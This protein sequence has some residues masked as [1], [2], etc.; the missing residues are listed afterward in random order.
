MASSMATLPSDVTGIIGRIEGEILGRNAGDTSALDEDMLARFLLP[1]P[2]RDSDFRV[3]GLMVAEVGEVTALVM[4]APRDLLAPESAEEPGVLSGPSLGVLRAVIRGVSQSSIA[5]VSMRPS[6]G[7]EESAGSGRLS[8]SITA[9]L[10][11]E[12][13]CCKPPACASRAFSRVEGVA[14]TA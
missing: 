14:G 10:G 13:G 9:P 5:E 8:S 11:E 1:R 6:T 2:P 12:R 3:T 7:R 4:G